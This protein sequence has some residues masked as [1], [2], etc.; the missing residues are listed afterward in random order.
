[1]SIKLKLATFEVLQRSKTVDYSVHKKS[2]I[3]LLASDLLNTIVTQHSG[4]TI[5]IRLFGIRVNNFK[6]L[7]NTKHQTSIKQFIESNESEGSSDKLDY[8]ICPICE[9][10]QPPFIQSFNKHIDK[11]IAKPN[12][13]NSD[14]PTT[15]AL[16]SNAVVKN[17]K[18]IKGDVQETLLHQKVTLPLQR[19]TLPHQTTLFDHITAD[20]VS[21]ED[22]RR[23]KKRSRLDDDVTSGSSVSSNKSS[24][25]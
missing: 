2:Q 10:E 1:M 23:P 5:I 14:P 17:N 3:K 20:Q 22:S 13:S 25:E 11:C 21:P 4:K 16:P 18:P 6:D 15:S 9:M 24:G 7:T 8:W 19:A 12:Q